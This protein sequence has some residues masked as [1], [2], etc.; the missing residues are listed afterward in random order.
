MKKRFR[1]TSDSLKWVTKSE[2]GSAENRRRPT[3]RKLNFIHTSIKI[4]TECKNLRIKSEAI[5]KDEDKSKDDSTHKHTYL[6]FA[7][8]TY[9]TSLLI[10][11]TMSWFDLMQIRAW[12]SRIWFAFSL[13]VHKRTKHALQALFLLCYRSF[14]VLLLLLF[15]LFS[16]LFFG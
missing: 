4:S 9:T 14:L 11:V 1:M 12:K 6:Q 2:N 3:L 8:H 16:R 13:F 15:S 10:R 7:V 5:S